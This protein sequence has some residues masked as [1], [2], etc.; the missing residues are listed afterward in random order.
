MESELLKKRLGESLSAH[1]KKAGYTQSELGEKLNY[2][3]KSISKWERGDGLPDVG[4]IIALAQMYGVTTDELLG[5]S[6]AEKKAVEPT[7]RRAT[8]LLTFSGLIWLC[9]SVIFIILVLFAPNMHNKWLCFV[10]ALPINAA[11]LCALF[12]KWR[13]YGWAFG[14]LCAAI[15]TA[16]VSVHLVFGIRNPLIVYAAGVL[17]QL[18]AFTVSGITLLHKQK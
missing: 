4:V 9:A 17:L 14:A 10:V 1:R 6:P 13:S 16:C 11:A 5:L 8:K 12:L 7:A 15:W 18:A 2:S 3:D